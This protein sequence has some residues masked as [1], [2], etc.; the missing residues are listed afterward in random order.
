MHPEGASPIDTSKSQ[1][2]SAQPLC[3]FLALW[4]CVAAIPAARADDS[5]ADQARVVAALDAYNAHA[6]MPLSVPAGADLAALVDG[7]VVKLRRRTRIEQASGGTADRIRIVGYRVID[8]PRLLVWLAA[9]NI[10]TRHSKRLT[11][12]LVQFDD[13]GGSVW[14]QYL[15]LP[16]P[17]KNRHWII[18]NHKSTA[19]TAATGGLVWEHAWQLDEGGLPAALDMLGDGEV[20]GL[21]ERDGRRAIYLPVNRGG[22]AMFELGRDRTLVAI[23]VMTVMGGWI[24]DKLVANM[25]SDQL[26]DMLDKLEPRADAVSERYDERYPIFTGDA[27]RITRDMAQAAFNRYANRAASQ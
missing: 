27:T 15:N 20:E 11:E 26:E 18:R 2:G 17:L 16:W 19:L 8:R 14:Y 5:A 1:S 25:A 21:D 7:S 6:E 23:H 12:H 3:A 4:L 13:S 10:D 9:L 22:W 24:P